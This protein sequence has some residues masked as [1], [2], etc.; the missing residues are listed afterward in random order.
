MKRILSLGLVTP[1]FKRFFSLFVL[2]LMSVSAM[3]ED[4]EVTVAQNYNTDGSVKPGSLAAAFSAINK[5]PNKDYV[6]KFSK[7]LGTIEISET[8]TVSNVKSLYLH[9][10]K[11]VKVVCDKDKYL[12]FDNIGDL[13]VDSISFKTQYIYNGTVASNYKLLNIKDS[14]AVR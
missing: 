7:D 13:Q 11:G 14:I 6:L 3:A 12:E 9:G 8:L 2:L 4:I 5:A 1:S 10:K